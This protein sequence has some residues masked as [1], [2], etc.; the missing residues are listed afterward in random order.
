MSNKE[1][2]G[3][4]GVQLGLIIRTENEWEFGSGVARKSWSIP[5]VDRF[6]HTRHEKYFT[7]ADLGTVENYMP[8]ILQKKNSNLMTTNMTS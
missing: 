4:L 7:F 3:E 2:R 8:E 6:A 1:T 5:R